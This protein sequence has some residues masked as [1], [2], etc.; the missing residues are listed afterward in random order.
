MVVD[1]AGDALAGQS[2][3]PVRGRR[4][5]EGVLPVVGEQGEVD[6]IPL[7]PL[8]VIG[9]PMKASMYP[10][11]GRHVAG[12]DLEQEG[13]IDGLQRLLHSGG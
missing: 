7:P 4:V 2:A 11:L 6:G 10:P 8:S 1:Y 9:L 12:H 13:V 5:G 3:Q